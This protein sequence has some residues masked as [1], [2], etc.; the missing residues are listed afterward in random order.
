MEPRQIEKVFD[1]EEDIEELGKKLDK[2][3][4]ERFSKEETDSMFIASTDVIEDLNNL[5]IEEIDFSDHLGKIKEQALKEEMLFASEEFDIFGGITEDKTKISS[6]GNTKHREIEKSKF[7]LLEINK[8]TESEQYKNTLNEIS[9]YL[10]SAINKAE[11]GAKLNA[12]FASTGA[13]NNQKYAIL[14]INPKNALDTLKECEKINLYNLKL[15]ENT[16]AV[17][18]TNII[19]YDNTNETLPVRNECV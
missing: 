13:L 1:Y 6:L 17:A 15:N 3:N 16:K 11:F 19:Y 2:N 5:E 12:F 18:L 8:N 14:Y 7:R 9:T 4:R 10:D